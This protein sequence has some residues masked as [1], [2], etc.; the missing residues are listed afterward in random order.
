MTNKDNSLIGGMGETVKSVLCGKDVNVVSLGLPDIF[1]EHGK[2][3]IIRDL[4]GI[5]AEKIEEQVL[6]ILSQAK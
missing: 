1:V 4:C 5:S 6:K 3:S 2:Q